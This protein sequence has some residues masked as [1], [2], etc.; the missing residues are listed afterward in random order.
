MTLDELKATPNLQEKLQAVIKELYNVSYP[1]SDLVRR[2]ALKPE[3]LHLDQLEKPLYAVCA[4]VKEPWVKDILDEI[5]ED[6]AKNPNVQRYIVSYFRQQGVTDREELQTKMRSCV[7]TLPEYLKSEPTCNNFKVCKYIEFAQRDEGKFADVTDAL[8][9]SKEAV[10]DYGASLEDLIEEGTPIDVA[11]NM[12]TDKTS[13]KFKFVEAMAAPV[14]MKYQIR[15]SLEQ[16]IAAGLGEYGDE[17]LS[18]KK[19]IRERK[20]ELKREREEA[21]HQAE[22]DKIRTGESQKQQRTRNQ[23]QYGSSYGGYGNSYGGGMYGNQRR[24]LFGRRNQMGYG[25]YGGSIGMRRGGFGL[26]QISIILSLLIGIVVVVACLIMQ[27]G[28]VRVGSIAWLVGFILTILGTVKRSMQEK[29]WPVLCL[30]GVL[31]SFVGVF[32]LFKL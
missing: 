30:S 19:E 28:F 8:M 3:L 14:R 7:E 27:K 10:V 22:L 24:G 9:G 13:K 5:G 17:Y 15:D 25:G 1:V 6:Y 20:A 23:S 12:A 21:K 32:L 31:V 29:G 16:S 11:N 18:N 4:L 2:A 26:P